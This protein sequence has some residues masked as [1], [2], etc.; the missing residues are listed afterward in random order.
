LDRL[1]AYRNVLEENNL[2]DESLICRV[3]PH[4]LDGAQLLRNLLGMANRPT[5]LFIADPFIAVG[6][7]N[8]AHK[9][10]VRLPEDLSIV[11]FDDS[12]LR[13]VIYPRMSAVCQD[14][15][16]LGRLAFEEVVRLSNQDECVSPR[17]TVHSAW[18]EIGNTTALPP[19][20][21]ER[22]LPTGARLPA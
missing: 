2:L 7:I 17:P 12:D 6:A 20:N 16:M 14:A 9:L 21:P 15:Q 1:L 8:E 3:P 13:N 4:R 11:G 18:L 19:K 22:I 10:G 5:A